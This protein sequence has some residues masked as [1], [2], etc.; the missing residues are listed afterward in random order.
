MKITII[1]TLSKP[2]TNNFHSIKLSHKI[3]H[4]DFHPIKGTAVITS[5]K[6]ALWTDGRYFLQASMQLD[7]NWVLMKQGSPL[8]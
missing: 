8:L 6:A 2:H 5:T 3:F 7:E 1:Q 4:Y